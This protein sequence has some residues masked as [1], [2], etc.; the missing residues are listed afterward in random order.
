[1]RNI[2]TF[3]L[4]IFLLFPSACRNAEQ[5]K[6][7]EGIIESRD[8]PSFLKTVELPVNFSIEFDETEVQSVDS[9]KIHKAIPLKFDE[10]KVARELLQGEIVA[11]DVYAEGPCSRPVTRNGRNTSPFMTEATGLVLIQA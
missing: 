5:R 6:S 9:A 7:E 8:L 1:M 4:L 11:S 3:L 2:L 10:N